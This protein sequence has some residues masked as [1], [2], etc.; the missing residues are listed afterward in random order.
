MAVR[1]NA[2]YVAGKRTSDPTSLDETFECL[3]D[4]QGMAWIGLYRPDKAEIFAVAK[5]F[6]LHPLAVEDAITAHQRP[7]LERYDKIGRAHV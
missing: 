6:E 3:R 4:R 1:D 2:I 5:E 7:K